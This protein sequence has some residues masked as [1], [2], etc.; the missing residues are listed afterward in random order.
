M[1]GAST[2]VVISTIDLYALL[3]S[4]LSILIFLYILWMLY[5]ILV[6]DL[7]EYIQTEGSAWIRAL[8]KGKKE[9]STQT[10]GAHVEINSIE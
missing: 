3:H 10:M 4:I 8:L 7:S 5:N 6:K 9:A 1:E 2:L